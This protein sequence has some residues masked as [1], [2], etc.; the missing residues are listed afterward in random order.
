MHNCTYFHITA[1]TTANVLSLVN[2]SYC[3]NTFNASNLVG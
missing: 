2:L 3:S 1:N